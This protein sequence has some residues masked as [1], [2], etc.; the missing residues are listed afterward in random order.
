MDAVEFLKAK[1]RMCENTHCEACGLHSG[2]I[3]CVTYC[4]VYPDEA[5]AAVE[6]WAKEH[7][8]MTCVP[9]KLTQHKAALHQQNRPTKLLIFA[10]SAKRHIGL[11]R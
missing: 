10:T 1:V 2:N 4:F 6:K 8:V 3:Y 7:P 11:R 9:M 5:V